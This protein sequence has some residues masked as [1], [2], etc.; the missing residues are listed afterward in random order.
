MSPLLFLDHRCP[1]VIVEAHFD[2]IIL[3]PSESFGTEVS[4]ICKK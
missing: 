1:R 3:R 4:V 2:E